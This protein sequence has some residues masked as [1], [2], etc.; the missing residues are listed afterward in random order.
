MM[1]AYFNDFANI[2]P[3]TVCSWIFQLESQLSEKQSK[4]SSN[5]AQ[6]LSLKYDSIIHILVL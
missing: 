1:T 5:H 4:P 6:H 3:A 2:E